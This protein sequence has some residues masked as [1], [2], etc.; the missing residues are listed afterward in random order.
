MDWHLFGLNLVRA[1]WEHKARW[2]LL[3]APFFLRSTGDVLVHIYSAPP[4][5]STPFIYFVLVCGS[6]GCSPNMG[7]V[8]SNTTILGTNH[9]DSLGLKLQRTPCSRECFCVAEL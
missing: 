5:Q 8:H 7:F 1:E 9:D 2:P 4:T 6:W 3:C